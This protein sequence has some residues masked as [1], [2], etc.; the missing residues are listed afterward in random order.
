MFRRR[1]A[2]GQK[3]AEETGEHEKSPNDKRIKKKNIRQSKRISSRLND[4]RGTRHFVTSS[5]C[6][7]G[8]D[9]SKR[10]KRIFAELLLLL[11]VW[12]GFCHLNGIWSFDQEIGEA[13]RRA[14]CG[15][16]SDACLTIRQGIRFAHAV[17]VHSDAPCSVLIRL[18]VHA[19]AADWNTRR[20]YSFLMWT[21]SASVRPCTQKSFYS[22]CKSPFSP[23]PAR[24]SIL[25][26]TRFSLRPKTSINHA[27][28]VVLIKHLWSLY[29]I[30]I[31]S[32]RWK[33]LSFSVRAH[34]NELVHGHRTSSTQI[35]WHDS[36]RTEFTCERCEP[37]GL[38][39]DVRAEQWMDWT[40]QSH[41]HCYRSFT[42]FRYRRS[43]NGDRLWVKK[44]RDKLTM[45]KCKGQNDK[46]KRKKVKSI[47]KFAR[48]KFIS[49]IPQSILLSNKYFIPA[50]MCSICE[51]IISIGVL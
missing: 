35:E 33:I 27:M 6:T 40:P 38:W 50:E 32:C 47:I 20:I 51:Y 9:A 44:N 37:L 21:R 12:F 26:L 17:S 45:T 13:E 30:T 28:S 8:A 31:G 43:F 42:I 11:L 19:V 36:D 14:A 49:V 41:S 3:S 10:I 39:A 25:E 7:T 15:L 4:E 48:A 2:A 29:F 23:L 1:T 5:N 16:H 22:S 46:Q 24:F 34:T 18:F